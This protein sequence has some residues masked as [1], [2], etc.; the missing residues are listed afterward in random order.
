MGLDSRLIA[1]H[2]GPP[3]AMNAATP[4]RQ[5]KDISQHL[6]AILLLSG[7]PSPKCCLSSKVVGG[8]RCHGTVRHEMSGSLTDYGHFNN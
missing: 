8:I 5:V 6:Q 4:L 1:V 3:A 2:L 7:P